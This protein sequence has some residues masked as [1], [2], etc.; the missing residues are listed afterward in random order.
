MTCPDSDLVPAPASPEGPPESLAWERRVANM[1]ERLQKLEA[2]VASLE[3]AGPALAEVRSRPVLPPSLEGAEENSPAFSPTEI[4]ALV[5]RVCLILA[6][7][8]LIRAI[9]DAGTLPR[10]GGVT[11]GLAYAAACAILADRVGQA[12]RSLGAGFYALAAALIAYP[13][14]WEATTKFGVLSPAA[15]AVTLVLVT[16]LL[17]TVAWRQSLNGVIWVVTLAAL[18]TGFALMVTTFAI[19][20]FTTVFL[21]FG[22]GSIWLTYGRRWHGLRWPVAI[23][24]DCVVLALTTLAAWPGGPPEA[25]RG[26]SVPRVL[27]LALGLVLVYLGSLAMRILQ[28][29]RAVNIFEGLQTVAVLIIGFGG[30]VRVAH[31]SGAGAVLLGVMALVF[32]VGCYAIAFAFVERQTEAGGNFAYFTSLALVLVLAGGLISVSGAGLVFCFLGLG[33]LTAGLGLRF[34]RVILLAHGSVYLAAAALVSGLLTRSFEAYLWP[35]RGSQQPFS[36][37]GIAVL[38]TLA[39]AH[40]LIVLK[41]KD[42]ALEWYRKL[43]SFFIGTM[44]VLGMGALAMTGL[45]HLVAGTPPDPGAVAAARTSVLA[46]SAVALALLGRW[47]PDTEMGWLVYPFL[48]ASA[49]KLLLEDLPNGRPLTLFLALGLFGAALIAAP[50]LLRNRSTVGHKSG[51]D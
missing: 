30:A 11:L 33:L 32:G 31:A 19:E 8:F 44:A 43:P 38:L 16:S 28:R 48:A 12:G 34:D 27:A 24:A 15:A 23:T 26:L 45:S 14:L 4:L 1:A 35:A 37:P 2:R 46:L 18:G 25:Y 6:G 21:L 9:T 22:A 50:W 20:I 10:P 49:L 47:R 42:G 3:K 36:L 5:G 29:H 40:L 41:R 13:L 51:V 39:A 17:V 7:A